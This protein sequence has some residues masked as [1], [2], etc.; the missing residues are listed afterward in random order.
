[1]I[2]LLSIPF[3]FLLRGIFTLYRLFLSPLLGH[4]CRFYPTCSCYME[5]ALLTH[6]LLKGGW[7]GLKRLSQ[8][9]PWGKEGYDPVASPSS[10]FTQNSSSKAL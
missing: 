1:M 10:L 6:G 5:E 2:K 7:F 9:H 8:C 4:G 3:L